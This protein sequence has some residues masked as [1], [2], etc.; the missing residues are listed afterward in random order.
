MGR[1]SL[2]EVRRPQILEAYAAC[3]LK[4]GVQGTTLDRVAH[5][6]GV[7]RGLVRH[8][9][10]NREE[11]LRAL[12][13]HVRDRYTTWLQELVAAPSPGDRLAAVLEALLTEDMPDE[14]YA[15]V[16]A[17]FA[18]APRDPEVAAVLRDLY[19]EFEREIDAELAAAV[20]TADPTSRRR[21]AFAILALA[22]STSDFQVIGFRGHRAAAREAA[23]RLVASLR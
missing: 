17:L 18:E 21:V 11:V 19:R 15:L 10:G 16:A 4:Y 3:L 23:D 22:F 6:A 9:L 2:A 5:E 7:S 13:E 1:P 12:G 14:L 8:Y 20:P